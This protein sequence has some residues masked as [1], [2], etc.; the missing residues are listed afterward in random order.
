MPADQRSDPGRV[1]DALHRC[2]GDPGSSTWVNWHIE[3]KS[4]FTGQFGALQTRRDGDV[5]IV[6]MQPHF[7]LGNAAGN[8]HGGAVMTFIDMAAFIG[9]RVLGIGS[10]PGGLT[11]DLNV[12]FTGS[13]DLQRPVDA[14]V[15]ITRETGGFLFIRGTIEQAG[16]M[17]SGFIGLL[18]KPKP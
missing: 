7:G 5:A 3:D 13:A 6:R 2:E 12:Q 8:M 10:E 9:A 18:R 14:M 1:I 17:I 4:R 11:V 15:Q 16:D